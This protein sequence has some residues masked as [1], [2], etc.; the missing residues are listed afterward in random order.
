M[1]DLQLRVAQLD[2]EL[3]DERAQV[4]R[5]SNVGPGAASPP[6]P[7]HRSIPVVCRQAEQQALQYEA[8]AE[9][10]AVGRERSLAR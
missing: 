5:R 10:R 6:G 9:V 8:A 3:I 4:S 2:R 1:E 7:T